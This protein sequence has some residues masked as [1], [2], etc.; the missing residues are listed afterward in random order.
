M[1]EHNPL[2]IRLG[3]RLLT[4]QTIIQGIESVPKSGPFII[5]GNHAGFLDAPALSAVILNQTGQLPKFPTTPWIW[6]ALS[7]LLGQKRTL[8]LGVL[9]IEA[10]HPGAVL[11]AAQRHLM[12]GGIIG[13]FPEGRRNKSDTLLT[14]KTGAVRLALA[15]HAPIIPVG[16]D[17]GHGG[18]LDLL[19][20]VIIRR[21]IRVSIGQPLYFTQPESTPLTKPQLEQLTDEVMRAISKI[22]GKRFRPR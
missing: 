21:P 12:S 16:V 3:Q 1:S 22:S 9:P 8:A 5:A 18:W 6:R 2:L 4:K 17:A 7:R 20:G 11:D 19:I 10:T 14:G 13:I 15:T